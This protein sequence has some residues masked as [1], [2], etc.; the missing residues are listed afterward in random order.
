[1]KNPCK[2]CPICGKKL[3]TCYYPAFN[4][5]KN[6]LLEFC[7]RECFERYIEYEK[8]IENANT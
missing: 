2:K 3:I 1:M 6:L 5:M 8:D 7:S 4:I